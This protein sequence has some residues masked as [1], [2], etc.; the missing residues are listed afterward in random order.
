MLTVFTGNFTAEKAG[1]KNK[2]ILSYLNSQFVA[3][4]LGPSQFKV[5][6]A[7]LGVTIV[8]LHQYT[9]TWNSGFVLLSLEIRRA[10]AE[11]QLLPKTPPGP[12]QLAT[13]PYT[14]LSK[15]AQYQPAAEEL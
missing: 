1:R 10:L 3:A 9:V 5:S 11:S 7:K 2:K 13:T 8:L 4:T 14:R 15:N 12:E 6:V